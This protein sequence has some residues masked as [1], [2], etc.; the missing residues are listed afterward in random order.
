MTTVPTI[1]TAV[2]TATQP[3]STT[4]SSNATLSSDFETFLE[5]LTAQARYQDPL[6]PISSSDYAAQLAQFSMVEQQVFTND[7]L[8]AL[9]TALGGTTIN[10]LSS[11]IG[12]EARAA[13][14]ARFD[15]TPIAI[16]PDVSQ[17]ADRAEL[18]VYND[19]GSEVARRSI[20]VS[21]T[22]YSWN[23]QTQ[24]GQTLGTG[25]YSF[26][27]ES[28]ANGE[29][30]GTAPAQVYARVLEAQIVDGDTLLKLEGGASV[31]ANQITALRA[32]E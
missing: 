5:M 10:A 13:S 25:S 27:V 1:S 22:S 23:G 21:S 3:A 6:D 31:S 9:N 24:A 18:V 11:W 30:M 8:G 16:E 15:G 4:P 7:Q 12:M 14:S 26:T 17:G 2:T 19:F 29:L 32:P 20:S 28:F